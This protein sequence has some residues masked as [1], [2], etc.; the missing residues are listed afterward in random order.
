MLVNFLNP[1]RSGNIK[2]LAKEQKIN[3]VLFAKVA[4]DFRDFC[5]R[6]SLPAEL[7]VVLSDI[8][9]VDHISRF[10]FPL[11]VFYK[12]LQGTAHTDELFPFFLAHA[13]RMYPHLECIEDLTAISDLTQPH[14]W[15]ANARQLSR[16]II[17]HAGLF[18]RLKHAKEHVK[19]GSY[20]RA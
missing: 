11:F 2:Q 20:S 1:N 6:G 12:G 5:L 9:K 19:D 15:F 14:E 13:R 8:N 16:S 3:D 4:R 17:Y 10:N 18:S 7:Y